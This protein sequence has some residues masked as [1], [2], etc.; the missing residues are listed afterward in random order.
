M[1]DLGIKAGVALLVFS[2][3]FL[4][5]VGPVVTLGALVW[6][7]RWSLRLWRLRLVAWW[8]WRRQARTSASSDYDDALPAQ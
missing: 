2:L 5:V 3:G 8:S 1:I 4:L 7:Q 6:S